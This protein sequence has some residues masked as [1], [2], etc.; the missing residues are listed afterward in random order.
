MSELRKRTNLKAL[1]VTQESY[2]RVKEQSFLVPNTLP[3]ASIGVLYGK[4]G[5]GKTTYVLH[6]YEQ[7]L[8]SCENIRVYFIDADMGIDMQKKYG[9]DKIQE[10]YSTNLQIFDISTDCVGYQA[11]LKNIINEQKKN[12]KPTFVVIDCLNKVAKKKRGFI[13]KDEL[14]KTERIV[15]KNG[16]AVLFLH[17]TNKNK[18]FADTQQIEDFADYTAKCENDTAQKIIS[19]N[20]EKISRYADKLHSKYYKYDG[21]KIVDEVSPLQA[22]LSESEL[23]LINSVK[24]QLKVGRTNQSDLLEVLRKDTKVKLGQNKKRELLKKFADEGLWSFEQVPNENNAIYYF[25][26]E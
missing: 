14:Y 4:A 13:D 1:L 24:E 2:Q 9:L 7:I 23:A 10:K 12:K 25:K 17:H 26:K 19:I 16:G 15:R 20:Y 18:I 11:I 21:L 8:Q 5:S 22:R 3:S 6:L